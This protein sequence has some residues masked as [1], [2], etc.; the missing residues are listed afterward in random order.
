MDSE[1]CLSPSF[2]YSLAV[3]CVKTRTAPPGG[4]E[5]WIPAMNSITP[6]TLRDLAESSFDPFPFVPVVA[7]LDALQG[8]QPSAELSA[9]GERLLEAA[10]G[11]MDRQGLSL[12]RPEDVMARPVGEPWIIGVLCGR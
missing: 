5:F 8:L 10:Q 9:A 7:V 12:L 11:F 4:P 6:E 1:S 3:H 2:T